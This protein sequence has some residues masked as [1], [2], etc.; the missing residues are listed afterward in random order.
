MKPQTIMICSIEDVVW[1]QEAVHQAC[2]I[3]RNEPANLVLVQMLRVQ[4]LALLGTALERFK[5]DRE[6]IEFYRQIAE[7]YGLEI[8]FKPFQYYALTDAIVDAAEYLQAYMVFAQLPDSMV[9]LW[10]K[11]QMWQLRRRLIAQSCQLLTL[12]NL[13]RQ[14]EITLTSQMH[15]A[16]K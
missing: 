4:H 5:Y 10:R 9:K 7:D 14:Y 16:H 1:T 3:A 13:I 15:Y 12:E 11:Y 8:S 6:A 2:C